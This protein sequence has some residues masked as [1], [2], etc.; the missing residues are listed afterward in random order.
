MGKRTTPKRKGGDPLGRFNV[1]RTRDPDSLR[2]RLAPLYAVT[3]LELPRSRV[4]FDAAFNHH[5]LQSVGLSYGR[6]GSPVQI[7]LSDTD[8]Y[9]QGFGVRG[10]GEAITDGRVFKVSSGRGGAAGPGASAFLNYHADFEH[11]FLKIPPDALHRK[12]SALLGNPVGRPLEL[13]GEYDD[14]ALTAQ[15]QLL[16]FVISELDRAKS[17]LPV[18]LLSEFEQALITAY[19]C[20]NLNNYTELLNAKG[21]TVAPWQ[22]QRA[23][24]Y[25]EANWDQPIT[26]EALASATESSARSLFATFRKSRGCSP[27]VFVRNVRLLRARELLSLPD[28]EASVSS[29]AS[30]CGFAS[31]SH[32]AKAYIR[33]F[34]E[35]PSET[36]ERAKRGARGKQ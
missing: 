24:D 19:L 13:R 12:V 16:R 23:I 11:V 36:L 18:L 35:P 33:R 10:Q 32:F 17:G 6:Y 20:A 31:P 1:L 9:T 3:K 4:R 14:A 22:V 26:I 2:D 21:R 30:R 7:T 28:S 5:Q 8:F 34:D 29:I 25:I 15:Y 27:M